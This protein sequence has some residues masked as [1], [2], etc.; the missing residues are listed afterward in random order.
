MSSREYIAHN[1]SFKGSNIYELKSCYAKGCNQLEVHDWLQDIPDANNRLK[2]IEVRFKNTR[3]EYVENVNGLKL[4]NG[5]I[6]VVEASVGYDVGIV[7]LMG[8]LVYE[9]LK[10][11]KINPQNHDFKKI[12]RKAKE[13]DIQ[14]WREAIRRE[15]ELLIKSREIAKN[16]KLNMKIGDVEFQ[17]DKTKAIFYYIADERV[18]FRELIKVLAEKLKIRIEM[19]QIGARQ[20]AGRIGSIGPCGQSTCCTSWLSTFTSVSTNAARHQN[21]SMNPQK[22]AGQCGKLKCCLN[23]EVATYLDTQ[24][25]FPKTSIPL[26]TEKGT[27]HHKNTDVL[28]RTMQYAYADGQDKNATKGMVQISV[29]RVKEIIELNKKGVIPPDLEGK[30]ESLPSQDEALDYKN[31]VGQD[32]LDRFSSKNKNNRNKRKKRRKNKNKQNK[33]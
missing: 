30:N 2:I 4:K 1:E 8:H 11:S 27:A 20:E 23:F 21:V 5:D 32:N 10:K 22:L 6:I 14:K 7:S 15:K 18:D 33:Q 9:Q 19:R 25:D 17:G 12:Y 3:K 29:E 28:R 26:K 31:A 13:T 24:K 16:L